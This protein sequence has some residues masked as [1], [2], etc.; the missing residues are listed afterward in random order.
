MVHN[1][2]LFTILLLAI[3]GTFSTWRKM[4]KE[5]HMSS[6]GS[7]NPIGSTGS[8]GSGG[9]KPYPKGKKIREESYGI[10]VEKELRK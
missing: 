1:E 9:D 6:V 3:Y 5:F 7:I 2:G 8:S 4:L 10:I